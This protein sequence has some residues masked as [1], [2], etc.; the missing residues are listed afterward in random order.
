MKTKRNGN[1]NGGYF[2]IR[3]GGRYSGPRRKNPASGVLFRELFLHTEGALDALRRE[4]R[5]FHLRKA[6]SRINLLLRRCA[7]KDYARRG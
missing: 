4:T 3:N 2:E 5:V 1:G 6:R 7:K